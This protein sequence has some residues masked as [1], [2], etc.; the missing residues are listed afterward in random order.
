MRAVGPGGCGHQRL[1]PSHEETKQDKVVTAV[2]ARHTT[3][4]VG[5]CICTAV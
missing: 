4:Q 2:E 1:L 5:G 3:E